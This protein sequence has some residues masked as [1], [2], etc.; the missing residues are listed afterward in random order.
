MASKVKAEPGLTKSDKKQATS[1]ESWTEEVP[2]ECQ[3]PQGERLRKGGRVVV[4]A[5]WGCLAGAQRPEN[6]RSSDRSRRLKLGFWDHL[7]GFPLEARVTCLPFP[8]QGLRPT[9][10]EPLMTGG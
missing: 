5:C 6:Q 2:E 3:E 7:A 9:P 10:S 4:S 1:S 8:F